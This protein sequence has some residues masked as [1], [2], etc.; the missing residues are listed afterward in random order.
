MEF[1]PER[2]MREAARCLHCPEPAPCRVACPAFN[3]ISSA[4]TLIEK[5]KFIEAAGIY[6]KTSS[7]PEICGLVCPHGALCQGSCILN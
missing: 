1:D 2:A 4:M 3:D 7:L 5:G 6:H